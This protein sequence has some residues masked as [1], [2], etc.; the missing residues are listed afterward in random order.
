MAHEKLI[1]AI[2]YATCRLAR[3]NP[4]LV[5]SDVEASL[6][7][8]AE[9]YRTLSSGIY[10]ESAPDYI[11]QREL[12]E[13]LKAAVEDFKKQQAREVSLSSIRDGE[14]RDALIFLAQLCAARS[15]GRP[16]GRA[17]LDL[18]R[19]GFKPEE[20]SEPAS[21]IVLLP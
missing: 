12:Y 8:L 21:N 17:Y 15:N 19:R 7:A 11:L 16:K 9:T 14:I 4:Q 1:L 10:Y 18:L 13:V 20:F 3:N 6:Q 5:D 2:S